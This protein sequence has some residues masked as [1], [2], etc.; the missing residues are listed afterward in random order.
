D[1]YHNLKTNRHFKNVINITLLWVFRRFFSHC[2]F[3]TR[4]KCDLYHYKWW[5]VGVLH[6]ICVTKNP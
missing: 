1:V 6:V 5:F 2:A 3:F 4:H